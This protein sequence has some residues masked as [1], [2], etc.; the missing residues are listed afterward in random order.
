MRTKCTHPALVL[1]LAVALT[2][3]ARAAPPAGPWRRH[4]IDDSSRGADGTRLA[5]VN[6]DGRPDIVCGW[7]EGGVTRAYLNPGPDKA[8]ENWPAVTV[9]PTRSVED[10][11]FVDLDRDGAADVVTCCEGRTRSM[12]VHWAPRAKGKYLDGAAWRTEPLPASSK[13]MAWMFCLPMD[14]DGQ[15]G[16]DLV[17]AGKGG[18]AR[19]GWFEAPAGPAGPRELK[20]W[21]WHPLIDAAWIMSLIAEDMDA[22]GD[23][24]VVVTERKGKATGCYWL[25]KPGG[26]KEG[27]GASAALRSQSSFSRPWRR[28]WIGSRGKQ[29]MFARIVDLDGDGLRDLIVAQ[30]P[31]TIVFHRR[32]DRTGT[33][34]RPHEIAMPASAGT[35]KAVNAGDIDL[36]GKL[37]LVFTCEGAN[38]ER[39]GV[40]WLSY[41]K[42]VTDAAWRAGDISGAKGVKY[43][44]V[45]LLDLDADGDLDVLT[46]EERQLNAVVWYENPTR[47]PRASAAP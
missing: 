10:A 11:V 37:D 44:L 24:D 2:S 20:A 26:P 19:V 41:E 43:D 21:K 42:A 3:A 7:E 33:K 36:D 46:C 22:D 6:A 5:D 13:V 8:A 9:G 4:V 15:G 34:W 39:P 1:V 35:A 40:M 29:V 18:G 17:A 23:L 16:V 25:E 45:E 47:R 12:F 32:L 27:A 28:H 38:A 14:V 30:K 31:R